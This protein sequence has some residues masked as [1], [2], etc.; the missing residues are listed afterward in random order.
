[1]E[2]GATYPI[3]KRTPISYSQSYLARFKGSFGVDLK[4]RS[5]EEQLAVLPAYARS[6]GGGFPKWKTRLIHQNRD[7][8]NVHQKKLQGLVA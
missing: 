3:E 6:D 8:F 7:F 4:G 1:M 2:F 5:K